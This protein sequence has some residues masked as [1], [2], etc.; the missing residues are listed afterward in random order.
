MNLLF[1][2]EKSIQ[3]WFFEIVYIYVCETIDAEAN[4]GWFAFIFWVA[5]TQ[6]KKLVTELG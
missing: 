3:T 6:G 4:H 5:V 1:E 2:M